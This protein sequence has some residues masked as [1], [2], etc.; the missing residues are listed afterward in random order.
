MM[1]KFIPLLFAIIFTF[2]TVR[3]YYKLYEKNTRRY[4]LFIGILIIFW[5]LIRIIKGVTIDVRLER[6]CWYLYYL[7]LIFIPTLFYICSN[8]LLSKMNKKRKICIYVLSSVLLLLV[9][10]NDFH[11]L[12]FRFNNGI[13][14]HNDYNHYIG[15][16]LI[17]IWIF[18]LFGGGM[19]K[20]AINRLKIKRDLKVFLPLIILLIGL[21]Y[22][23][24]YILNIS[25][26]RKL[27]MSVVNSILICLGIELAFYL[28]LIPNNRKYM[29]KFLNSNL[30]MAIISLDGKTK[31]TTCAFK[32]VPDFILKDIK[33]NKLKN[34]YQKK[35]VVYDIKKN[36]D[37]YVILKKY[38]TNIFSLKDEIIRQKKELLKQQESMKLEEKTKRKLYEIKIR[39]DIITNVE[40]KLDEKRLEA[41]NILMKDDVSIKDLEKVKRIIIYSKKKSMLIISEMNNEVY[42][43]ESIKV[44]LNELIN[45][46]SSLNIDG[47]VVVKNKMNIN[48]NIMSYLYDI[49]YELMENSKSKNIMLYVF[50]DNNNVKLKAIIGT[51]EKIR[52]KLKLDLNVK[53]KENIYDTDNELEFTIKECDKL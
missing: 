36:K 4:I 24:L 38:L 50:T 46:M 34:T 44:L 41:K 27:D 1:N 18:Y 13:Y 26:A 11:E 7:P 47:L 2:W 14:L 53:V 45:S 6:I 21:I 39:K 17:F 12:V 29:Q 31:Y 5:M 15:Y 8:S 51:N 16:Y 48:G 28:D 40:K 42:N 19:I 30:D 25:Y 10:T 49:V 43:E 9:L 32:E 22:T 35:N 37:S 23:F 20:L 3:L 33:N 52:D